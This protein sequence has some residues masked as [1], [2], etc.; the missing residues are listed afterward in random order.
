MDDVVIVHQD[1]EDEEEEDA[2]VMSFKKR[3]IY[4]GFVFFVFDLLSTTVIPDNPRQE[5][6]AQSP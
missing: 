2:S 3:K 6:A 5:E 1:D 4:S